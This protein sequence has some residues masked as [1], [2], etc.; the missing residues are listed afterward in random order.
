ML[1][2]GRDDSEDED[3]SKDRFEQMMRDNLN[4]LTVIIKPT[5]NYNCI[6]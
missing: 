6:E 1:K 2:Q 5:R 3:Y 4:T